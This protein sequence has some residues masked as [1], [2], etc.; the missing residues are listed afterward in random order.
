MLTFSIIIIIVI[1]IKIIVNIIIISGQMQ[2][3]CCICYLSAT[4]TSDAK[5]RFN[6]GRTEIHDN[7]K[8]GWLSMVTDEPVKNI[9]EYILSDHRL[10]ID[11]LHEL[12]S[13]MP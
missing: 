12:Y 13:E 11:D 8:S 5:N 3:A 9:E 10:I 1:K 4:G 2:S 7:E 6:F